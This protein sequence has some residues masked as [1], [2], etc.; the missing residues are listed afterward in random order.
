SDMIAT[1]SSGIFKDLAEGLAVQG[2]AVLRFDKR[3]HAYPDK[4]KPGE[5]TL[6]EEVMEDALAALDCLRAN[7]AVDRQRL[8]IVGWSLGGMLAPAI[9]ERSGD[10]AGL[11]ILAGPCRPIELVMD[12][13]L[14]DRARDPKAIFNQ[15]GLQGQMMYFAERQALDRFKAGKS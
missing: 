3:S 10:A 5:W 4:R 15:L 8:F 6:E 14:E 11:V 1:K 9:A 7:P 13:Q 2:F 12:D